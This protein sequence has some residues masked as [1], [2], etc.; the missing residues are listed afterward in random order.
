M[1]ADMPVLIRLYT[2]LCSIIIKSLIAYVEV[3]FPY[4][5]PS[6]KQSVTNIIFQTVNRQSEASDKL[7]SKP[8]LITYLLKLPL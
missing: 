5:N 8:R 4:Y 3:M 6:L 7:E 2:C 1:T